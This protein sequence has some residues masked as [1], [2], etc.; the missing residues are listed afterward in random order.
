MSMLKKARI[1]QNSFYKY[2]NSN[3]LIEIMLTPMQK[4]FLELINVLF[5]L[6]LKLVVETTESLQIYV[7]SCIVIS[8]QNAISL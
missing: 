8:Y 1:S 5:N 3:C 4:I 7:T 2:F 6:N